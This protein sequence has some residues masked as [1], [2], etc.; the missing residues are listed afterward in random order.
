VFCEEAI[1]HLDKIQGFA[2]LVECARILKPGATIRIIT[3]DLDWFAG[4]LLDQS[5][6]CD[7]IN[8]IFFGHGHKYIYSR[9]ELSKALNEAGFGSVQHSSYKDTGSK[10]GFLDSHPDRFNHPPD[11][12]QYVEAQR[13]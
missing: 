1:E 11:I 2:L 8:E 6:N 5:I 12:S 3:P 4:R 13:P 10:L 9:H 7:T